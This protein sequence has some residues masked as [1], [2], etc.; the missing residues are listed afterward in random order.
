M[1]VRDARRVIKIRV[2]GFIM[3]CEYA[4]NSLMKTSLC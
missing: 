4:D 1:G 2:V 3:F